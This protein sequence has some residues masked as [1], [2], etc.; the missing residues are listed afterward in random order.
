MYNNDLSYKS[1]GYV[2]NATNIFY[3]TAEDANSTLR[4]RGKNGIIT[5]NFNL[6]S[7]STVL[8]GTTY[9]IA[10]LNNEV[11]PPF[12]IIND[13]N[14]YSGINWIGT[15]K[16]SIDNGVITMICDEVKTHSE[17]YLQGEIVFIVE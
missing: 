12:R 7:K 16:I 14:L 8:E 4:V 17:A 5:L 15:A 9:T 1:F 6:R 13:L 10:T 11:H 3:A 2:W